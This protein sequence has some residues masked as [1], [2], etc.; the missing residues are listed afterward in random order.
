MVV[1]AVLRRWLGPRRISPWLLLLANGTAWG[2]GD[3]TQHPEHDQAETLYLNLEQAIALAAKQGPEGTTARAPRRTAT[4][5]A[6]AA[7]P[8]VTQLPYVQTQVGPRRRQGELSPELIVG[9]NQPFTWG[10]VSGVQK[11]IARATVRSFDATSR[12]AQLRDAERAATAWV[13]LA[14][15]DH[16]LALRKQFSEQSEKL[17]DLAKARVAAGEA[18]PLE[19]ALAESDLATAN[20]AILTAEALHFGAEL[21]LAHAIGQ[22]GTHIDVTG[23]LEPIALEMND[24]GDAVHPA[25]LDAETR[26]ALATEQIEYA[27]LQQAPTFALGIQYQREG[28]G[29]EI[30]TAV[31]TLPLP[32]ARPWTFQQT[33]QRLAADTA[34]AEAKYV[35]AVQDKSKANARHELAHSRAQYEQLE[36]QALPPLREAHRIAMLRYTHGETDFTQVSLVRQRLIQTEERL[37]EAL[38]DVHL[39]R[40]R[41]LA[42]TGKLLTSNSRTPAP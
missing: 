38:A 2:H 19:V 31:A 32:V 42:T 33:Q 26:A 39:A 15:A 11:R 21:E 9:V 14:L 37:I 24:D 41:W 7:Q 22:P 10:D 16:L 20:A 13:E 34:R 25:V 8:F 5:L 27:K 3:H 1:L 35:R 29:E 18:Q 23:S 28:T 4:Q 17:L 40:L 30:L 12:S 36:Q 6:D